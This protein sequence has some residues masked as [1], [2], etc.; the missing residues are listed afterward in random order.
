MKTTKVA[1]LGTL[2]GLGTGAALMYLFDP[3]RGSRR[4]GELRHGVRRARRRVAET[5]REALDLARGAGLLPAPSP[6][7]ALAA[8]VRRFARSGGGKAALGTLLAAAAVAGGR[9]LSSGGTH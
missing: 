3:D 2:A 4:R 6:A 9:R 7:R 5:T 8:R 1:T